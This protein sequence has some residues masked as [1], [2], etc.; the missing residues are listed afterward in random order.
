MAIFLKREEAVSVLK[1]II[2]KCQMCDGTWVALMPPNSRNMLSQGYQVHMKFPLDE[3]AL[4]C[5]SRILEKNKLA[6]I[7]KNN[8]ELLIIYRP[9]S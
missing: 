8:N 2:D 5:I 4:A 7:N 1:E 6:M 3:T 9:K